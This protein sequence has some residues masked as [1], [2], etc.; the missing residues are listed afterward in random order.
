M[1]GVENV[2]T[3]KEQKCKEFFVGA[4]VGSWE[5]EVDWVRLVVLA[6]GCWLAMTISPYERGGK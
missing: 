4:G 2:E 3:N 1:M 6:A 5:E